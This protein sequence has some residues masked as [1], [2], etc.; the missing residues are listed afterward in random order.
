MHLRLSLIDN[1]PDSA[2]GPIELL[3]DA[4]P[5][6]TFADL[7]PA[8]LQQI[9]HADDIL[10][11]DDVVFEVGGR[12][13]ADDVPLGAPPLLRGAAVVAAPRHRSRMPSGSVGLA[14]LLV[15][16]GPGAGRTVSLGRG[17]HVVGRSI[18]CSVRLDDSDVSRAHCLVTVRDGDISVR[19]LH[20][21]NPSRLEGEPL[22]PGG[23]TLG[24]GDYLRVGSTTL[25]LRQ[26][27][28]TG[29]GHGT[30]D[31][32]V[33]VH[34][35][36]RFAPAGG[37]VEIHTPE[38]PK[39]PD[40]HR[41]PL[42]ASLA[43]LV[44]SGALAL[45]MRSP[46][47]LLFALM[48]PV[49]LIGQWWSD[50]RHGRL[51]YR[52]MLRQHADS[53]EAGASQL[54]EAL[55]TETRQRRAEHPDLCL[56]LELVDR[57][58]PRLWERQPSDGDWFVLR[59]GTATQPARIVRTGASTGEHPVVAEVPALVDLRHT[60]VLGIAGPRP[61]SLAVARS[62]TAQVAAWHSPRRAR[63]VLLTGSDVPTRDWDSTRLLPHLL[64]TQTG[65]ITCEAR[66]LDP[67]G[68]ALV[69]SSLR[70]LVDERAAGAGSQLDTRE[71]RQAGPVTDVLVVL[72]GA[73]ELRAVTGV[74][75]LLRLGP[76]QG[77]AFLCL[78][79]DRSSLPLETVAVVEL[80][81]RG[82]GACLTL[83][84]R[85]V[86]DVAPDLP[87]PSWI[88]Q[89]ARGLAPL[90]DATP[91]T[92]EG[93]LAPRV[94]FRELHRSRGLDPLD[95]DALAD[96]WARP[97]GAPRALLGLTASGPHEVDLARDGP[98]ALVGGTTGS[99]KS[100]LLQALVA[101]LAATHRP[102]DL[103]FVLVDYKGGAA[104]SECARLPHTLGLVTDLDEH[105]TSRALASL[106]AE[107]RRR[108]RIL[109]EAGAK[110]L[111]TYRLLRGSSHSAWPRLARLVIVVDEFKLLADELPDFV[112]GLVRIAATGRSLGVHLVLATQRPSG[113]ITGDMRANVSLRIC[114]R[115]RDRADSDD[116]IDDS[117]A[118]GLS[119]ASP[120]RAYLRAGDGQLVVLQTAH[121]GGPADTPAAAEG[122]SVMVL[123]GDGSLPAAK[124]PRAERDE[125]P[126]QAAPVV[127]TELAA[128]VDAARRAA[129]AG[130]IVTPTSPWLPPLPD[131]IGVDELATL[132]P[133]AAPPRSAGTAVPRHR[134]DASSP[135]GV[136]FGLVDLP[137]EQ[138][139][140][141]A[142]WD[143]ACD[144]HLG[145]I[146]GSR[147]G[148]TTFVR[149]L[150]TGITQRHALSE[151][152]VHVLASTPGLLTDLSALP[153][154]GTIV[155]PGDPTLLRRVVER[156]AEQVLG[157]PPEG[158]SPDLTVLVVDGW[159]A[160]D[161]ALSEA[162]GPGT[163]SLL[164]LI[165]DGATRGLRAVVTGGRTV[166]SGRLSSLL[167]RR[168]VLPMPDP[169]D[170]TLVG[171]EPAAARLRR[172]PG[173]AVDLTDGTEL[174]IATMGSGPTHAEQIA[175]VQRAATAR[176]SLSTVPAEQ[177]PWRIVPL[178]SELDLGTLIAGARR[179]GAT[180]ATR[181]GRPTVCLGVG[182]DAATPICIDLAMEAS[183]LLVVGP[184]R[185]G[186]SN[187]LEVLARQLIESHRQVAI[188]A[189][190]RSPLHALSAERGVHLLARED[191]RRFVDL[192]RAHPDLAALVDDAESLEGSDL[193][194]ALVEC[195]DLVDD[196]GGLVWAVSDT[197]RA[198]A[199]FRGLVPALARH[200]DGLVLC[201]AGPTDGDCLHARP[202]RV[203]RAAPGRGSL[204][205]HSRCL[206]IQVA[207]A[208]SSSA[209]DAGAVGPHPGPDLRSA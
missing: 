193:E 179:P 97:A 182:G 164:R 6:S 83:P 120:G 26:R 31:G 141:V 172:G 180:L 145:V 121:V 207:R 78:E 166:G 125:N 82:V 68:L 189:N 27:S 178:P 110:D 61:A 165:R 109:A 113:I 3:V 16:G 137:G 128:F 58:G 12:A 111:D 17:D 175:A 122:V 202:E 185:S 74:A 20:P 158:A 195:S 71:H 183:R 32:R 130:R 186:R 29:V 192:R 127:A 170:L 80:A 59:L 119:E 94:G 169:L 9:K 30:R 176:G 131:W 92:D 124:R 15:V 87:D 160:V 107:L 181:N 146:G 36:P 157:A 60:S 126:P 115:V 205:L 173:R 21:A 89:L 144:G 84:D 1:R 191:D 118:A 163:D 148:R 123:A 10:T 198:N 96:A 45:A 42:L 187:V 47:M 28:M 79:H 197:A 2:P 200:G 184:P 14:D 108:E 90:C 46:I 135:G 147:S 44:L 103:G 4:P 76:A 67:H 168:L 138:R 19:D 151:L 11:S 174:H 51:S 81:D 48:S 150:V 93:A 55:R 88:Q 24:P 101:G 75:D 7:R 204:V 188:V 39:R 199:A 196:S 162:V 133:T 41:L 25:V 13:L 56:L 8:L 73:R 85:V 201:P 208:Q 64:T 152:H 91:D 18:S 43:P 129:T 100:E 177:R 23:A 143:P 63:I 190:R 206:P 105:L 136:P 139:Q 114:L 66:T 34:V 57:R 33:L 142:R 50:R 132:D 5:G 171:L 149:T 86:E 53:L 117:G 52:R 154:V 40:G 161:D 209:P 155:D 95:A 102:D 65:E 156:L 112:S 106:T 194:R 134:L 159:E 77:L 153:H 37:S 22:P 54:S 69:V 98:H 62:L 104:F 167:D 38:E 140:E 203:G 35:R 70:A 49:I 116:V 72:D 99:G